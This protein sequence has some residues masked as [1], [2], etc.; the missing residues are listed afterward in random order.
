MIRLQRVGRKNDPSFRVVIMDKRKESQSGKVLEVL[1]AYDARSNKP[2]LKGERITY[3]IGNG[4][5]VS[6][7]VHNIL[8]KEKVIEGKKVNVL[9][10][11]SPIK[12]VEK[13]A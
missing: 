5:Q 13:K 3:W 9:P 6:P 2:V 8:V 11:K 10:R 1:G 12:K 7:T 4:A